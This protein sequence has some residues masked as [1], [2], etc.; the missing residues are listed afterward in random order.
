MAALDYSAARS[1]SPVIARTLGITSIANR[2]MSAS[3]GW[4]CS[5][6]VSIPAR[7]NATIRSATWS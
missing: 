6:N 2:R 5:M 3:N 4:Y 7:L 1:A